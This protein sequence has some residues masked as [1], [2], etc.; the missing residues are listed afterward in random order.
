SM[1]P[2]V[3]FFTPVGRLKPV[4]FVNTNFDEWMVILAAFALLLGVVSV[5]QIHLKK[6]RRFSA[7]W[8]YSIIV[9]GSLIT[10]AAFGFMGIEIKPDGSRPPFVWV[11]ENFFNPLQATMF[12]MTA[13]F[14]ASAAFRAFRIRNTEAF[15]MIIGALIIMLGRIPTAAI[16]SNI[17]GE[18]PFIYPLL[19]FFDPLTEWIMTKPSMAAQRGIILGAALGAASMSIRVILGIERPYMGKTK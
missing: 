3:A 16:F 12:S 14:I 2:I 18:V 7:G 4:M 8:G 5:I 13:F 17:F 6:I 11:F 15:I 10:M 1:I 9:L 19:K